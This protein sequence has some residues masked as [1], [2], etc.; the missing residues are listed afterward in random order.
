[1]EI[2]E[3]ISYCVVESR[4]LPLKTDCCV[5]GFLVPYPKTDLKLTTVFYTLP[6]FFKVG[7]L[8]NDSFRF[9]GS[10]EGCVCGYG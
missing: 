4:D 1:M 8:S 9:G 6:T 10:L 2:K 3:C 5:V 7:K